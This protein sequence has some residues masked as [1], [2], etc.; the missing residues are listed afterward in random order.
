MLLELVEGKPPYLNQPVDVVCHKIV[1]LAAP[2]IDTIKWSKN[3]RD[4]L[5]IC[6]VKDHLLRP[7]T[8][9]LLQHPFITENYSEELRE[10]AKQ[11]FLNILIPFRIKKQQEE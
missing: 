4:F 2:E 9:E 5:K 7:S 10:L 11:Q 6:L 8:Q 1:T 3:M